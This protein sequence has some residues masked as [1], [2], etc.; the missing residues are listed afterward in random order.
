MLFSICP[1][2]VKDK[3]PFDFGCKVNHFFLSHNHHRPE[4]DENIKFNINLLYTLHVCRENVVNSLNQVPYTMKKTIFLV[5]MLACA[6]TGWTQK[7]DVTLKPIEF[8][9]PPL[10][11][12][13]LKPQV[14][15]TSPN[16]LLPIRSNFLPPEP[17]KTDFKISGL[18]DSLKT[19]PEIN[20]RVKP[21]R[22]RSIYNFGLNPYSND[23]G[24]SGVIAPLGDGL[25]LG[26]SSY[27]TLPGLGT[28]GAG[29]LSL[30]GTID[31]RFTLTAS[32]SGMKY[33]MDRDIW[34]DYGVMGRASYKLNDRLSL[35]AFGQ[36]YIN[37]RYQSMASMGYMQSTSYG[38]TLGIK[39][40]DKVALDV[41]F[42]RYYDP[43][44]HTWRTLP[45]LAPT[46]NLFGQ[47]MSFDVGG[48]V[49]QILQA[50]LNKRKGYDGMPSG[51]S[52]QP[53]GVPH[54]QPQFGMPAR[55]Y[56]PDFHGIH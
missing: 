26:S 4:K 43:Y 37:Q 42:Q 53:S 29:T 23:F 16:I 2:V 5:L 52:G 56:V 51:F 14:T 40:S 11:T 25:L 18:S 45:V 34:N 36:Y 30:T 21:T 44:S 31:D 38:G 13:P 3:P 17:L 41:G 32:V 47:P 54:S 28:V 7:A 46:F 10:K 20:A 9:M 1:V 55:M 24:V 15:L 6:L 49:Y 8:H 48:F 33:H 39:I 22:S 27:T 19:L 12:L 35:N 50:V